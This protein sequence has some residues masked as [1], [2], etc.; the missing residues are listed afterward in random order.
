[1]DDEKKETMAVMMDRALKWS[2]EGQDLFRE[3]TEIVQKDGAEAVIGAMVGLMVQPALKSFQKFHEV[4]S[5]IAKGHM[6]SEEFK[7]DLDASS[8]GE[9]D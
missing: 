4:V 3:A 7:D 8:P 6:E 5:E 1:M 2:S 9:V